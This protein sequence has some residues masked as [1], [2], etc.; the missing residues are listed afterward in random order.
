MSSVNQLQVLLVGESWMTHGTHLK[1]MTAY[2][3]GTY[4]EGAGPLIQALDSIANVTYLPN[5]AATTRFPSTSEA[6]SAFDVVIFSDVGADTLL[7]HP[8]TL[9]HSK[10]RPNALETV[11]DFVAGGG[12]FA[13]IGGYMSFGGYEGK[14]HYHA[15]PIERLLPVIISPFDDR[16][17]VPQGFRPDV[18]QKHN[19]LDGVPDQWPPLLGYCRLQAKAHAT[20]VLAAGDDPLL[21]VGVH[22]DGR[23][24]AFAS[25]CSPHWGT[26]EFVSWVGYGQFWRNV[27][28][29]LAGERTYQAESQ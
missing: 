4:E 21:V 1:G 13:M 15:S 28:G 5:H 19:V 7:L 14:A 23:A 8:D 11:A 18:L 22:G 24:L 26:P 6:M 25:D 17:E 12:G 27:V 16:V 9:I 3:T 29:W 10:I 20:V 2:S